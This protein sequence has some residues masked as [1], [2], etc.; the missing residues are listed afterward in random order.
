[1]KICIH[2][3]NLLRRKK[4]KKKT[5]TKAMMVMARTSTSR[6][7]RVLETEEFDSHLIRLEGIERNQDSSDSGGCSCMQK[8]I[9]QNLLP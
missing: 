7:V 6:K 3:H 9:A 5:T 8:Q 1:M 4:K 2:L